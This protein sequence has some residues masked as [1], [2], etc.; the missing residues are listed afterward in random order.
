MD[1]RC[2]RDKHRANIWT[3][4]VQY[5]SEQRFMNCLIMKDYIKIN[6]HGT[7]RRCRGTKYMYTT[8]NTIRVN[9]LAHGVAEA[10]AIKALSKLPRNIP[11]T[12]L[13]GGIDMC[14]LFS[15][16]NKFIRKREQITAFTWPNSAI[17]IANYTYACFTLFCYGYIF[18]PCW[19]TWYV[20]RQCALF[21]IRHGN[22][23]IALPIP[24]R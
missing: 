10:L 12:A 19:Y 20:Y 5:I 2:K 24:E 16:S 3:N 1:E 4:D 21:F 23:R 13:K 14:R 18:G 11:V 9:V 15:F 6:S 8:C 17:Q 22:N 7:D